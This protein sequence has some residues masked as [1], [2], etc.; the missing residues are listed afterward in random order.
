MSY[1][2]EENDLKN[3]LVFLDNFSC[4]NLQFLNDSDVQIALAVLCK[5]CRELLK[6]PPERGMKPIDE[7]KV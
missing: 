5:K 1:K 4:R 7:E 6:N 3:M 2:V